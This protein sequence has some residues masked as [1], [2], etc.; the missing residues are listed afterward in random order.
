MEC[1]LLVVV[2]VLGL[3]T[4][5]LTYACTG[6]ILLLDVTNVNVSH[7]YGTYLFLFGHCFSLKLSNTGK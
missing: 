5:V 7:E 4:K 2:E 3:D 6:N 1:L